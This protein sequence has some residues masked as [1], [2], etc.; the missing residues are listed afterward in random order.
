MN[1]YRL[2]ICISLFNSTC[3]VAQDVIQTKNEYNGEIK[4]VWI[5]EFEAL[6]INDS[7]IKGNI[8][9]A[10]CRNVEK[11]GNI[12]NF[13]NK[14]GLITES[15]WLASD[16]TLCSKNIY[17]YNKKNQLEKRESYSSDGGNRGY[18]LY[19]YGKSNLTIQDDFFQG[20]DVLFC[21]KK[22]KYDKRKNVTETLINYPSEQSSNSRLVY[23]YNAASNLVEYRQYNWQDSLSFHLTY[24]YDQNGNKVKSNFYDETGKKTSTHTYSYDDDGNLISQ[25]YFNAEDKPVT[26]TNYRSTYLYDANNNWCLKIEYVNDKPTKIIARNISYY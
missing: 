16:S 22:F 26:T 18:H 11:N 24:E 3:L 21:S 13:Y 9:N 20:N 4:S 19:Q 10:L 14:T 5:I 23:I 8:L 15:H 25:I 1:L 6:D 12:I 2:I 7:I 17:T